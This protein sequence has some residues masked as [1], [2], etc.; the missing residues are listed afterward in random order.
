MSKASNL[1]SQ[2]LESLRKIE[3][4]KEELAPKLAPW[5][6]QI[7]ELN[8]NIKDREKELNGI[9]E[10][11]YLCRRA[12]V[13]IKNEYTKEMLAYMQEK[14]RDERT[15]QKP[16]VQLD[17]DKKIIELVTMFDERTQE[18]EKALTEYDK[19]AS[20]K[21]SVIS[22]LKSELKPIIAGRDRVAKPLEQEKSASENLYRAYE[23][24]LDRE[25]RVELAASRSSSSYTS[26]YHSAGEQTESQTNTSNTFDTKSNRTVTDTKSTSR[27]KVTRWYLIE[28]NGRK[29]CVEVESCSCNVGA[30]KRDMMA[31]YGLSSSDIKLSSSGDR[32]PYPTHAHNYFDGTNSH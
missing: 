19:Q 29:I 11:Q 6:S 26:S 8:K 24:E 20:A 18:Q 4:L 17:D 13:D 32:N 23:R 30:A 15:G 2:Y 28:K 9:N 7:D 12:K 27:S 3:K 5:E 1:Y 22:Q 14:I 25:I 16:I 21:E 31:L 10:R